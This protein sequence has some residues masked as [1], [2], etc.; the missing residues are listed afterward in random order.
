M[1]RKRAARGVNEVLAGEEVES[2][3]RADFFRAAAP[4]RAVRP[5]PEPPLEVDEPELARELA[6]AEAPA[7]AAPAVRPSHTQL[8]QR[9]RPAH[10]KV[11]CIS[12]YT[13]DLERLDESVAELKR[14]GFT[15]ANRSAVIRFALDQMDL[16]KVRRGL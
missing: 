14:R 4:P 8:T 10:Y 9:A 15:K 6:P 11:I 16:S 1:A 12:L 13:D 7:K 5:Q 2:I 3:L